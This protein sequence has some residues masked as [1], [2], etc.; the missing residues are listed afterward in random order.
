MKKIYLK[1]LTELRAIAALMVVFHHIELYKTREGFSSL[2]HTSLKDFISNAGKN[3][4]Y[5]F[6][7]LSGFL[8]SYLLLA[9]KERFERINVR[10][11]YIRRI[12][13]IWPL[14]YIIV[15]LCFFVLPFIADWIPA[16]SKESYYFGLIQ[17]LQDAPWKPLL[18]FIFFLP[19][20]AVYLAAPVAGASQAWSVGVEE[21]FYLIWPHLF[22]KFH[23]KTTFISVLV[24]ICLT[25]IIPEIVS[26]F[27]LN[28]SEK[29]MIIINIFPIHYM[30]FG[31][32]GAF[33][34][35]EPSKLI[36]SLLN[37]HFLFL[38][39]T[40]LFITFLFVKVPWYLHGSI[41]AT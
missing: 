29:A 41:I 6:F 9:E 1:G 5:I 36:T 4:V 23:N 10:K 17:T 31:A 39:N 24:F 38:F 33:F 20:L 12:L 11:F 30:A 22:N 28:L 34:L 27:D 2:F 8:I 13:R 21:Q 3:G 7:V 14:Y 16:L 32:I 15:F 25:P 18:L 26:L 35:F 19:N 40:I 37:N